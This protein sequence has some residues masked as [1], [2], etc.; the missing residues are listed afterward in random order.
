M[1]KP[2]IEIAGEIQE[3]IRKHRAKVVFTNKVVFRAEGDTIGA[4]TRTI[5]VYPLKNQS[6]GYSLEETGYMAGGINAPWLKPVILPVPH[7]ELKITKDSVMGLPKGT[8]SRIYKEVEETVGEEIM[9]DNKRRVSQWRETGREPD[10]VPDFSDSVVKA[11][12]EKSWETFNVEQKDVLEKGMI[13]LLNSLNEQP[14]NHI[15]LLPIPTK[16]TS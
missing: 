5:G 11:R 3:V 6:S 7:S 4:S 16:G 10:Y 14:N 1:G 2:L 15:V 8:W 9:Q 12:V 13:A